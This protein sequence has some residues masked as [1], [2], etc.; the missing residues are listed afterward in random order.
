M[1]WSGTGTPSRAVPFI[2]TITTSKFT[3]TNSCSAVTKCSIRVQRGQNGGVASNIDFQWIC[4]GQ[5]NCDTIPDIK[6]IKVKLSHIITDCIRTRI[7]VRTGNNG[8]GATGSRA[9]CPGRGRTIGIKCDRTGGRI[10]CIL[11]NK[12]C[13]R[14]RPVCTL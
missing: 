3:L 14:V 4:T 13:G 6:A 11:G 7:G 12:T 1:L 2:S 9:R 8:S 5:R 10:Q